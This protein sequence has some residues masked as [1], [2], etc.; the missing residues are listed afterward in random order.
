MYEPATNLNLGPGAGNEV[1]NFPIIAFHSHDRF[2]RNR[3][4]LSN[5]DYA[6][7]EPSSLLPTIR[8][9]R[10]P[11]VKWIPQGSPSVLLSKYR[12]S[13]TTCRVANRHLGQVPLFF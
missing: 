4:L 11:V 1:G 12:Q 3:S 2:G 10:T 6:S 13:H 9:G 5:G 7:T 8:S